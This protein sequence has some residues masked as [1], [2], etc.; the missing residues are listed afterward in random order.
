MCAYLDD[1]LVASASPESHESDLRALF[2]RLMEYGLVF[3]PVKCVLGAP[4][5]EFLG[6]IVTKSGVKVMEDKVQAV[7][8]FPV[9]TCVAK[10][11]EFMGFSIVLYFIF[12]TYIETYD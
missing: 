12:C 7:V 4:R 11:Q 8:D 5:V 10:V 1:I 9:P 3:N 2:A 6:H